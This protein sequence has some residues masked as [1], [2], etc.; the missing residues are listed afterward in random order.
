MTDTPDRPAN[1]CVL[2]RPPQEGWPWRLSDQGYM[3]CSPCLDRLRAQLV[4]IGTRYRRLDPTPGAQGNDGGRGAPGF[5]SKSPASDHVICLRDS[6]S[7]QTSRTWRGG[8]GRL[9]AEDEHPPISVWGELDSACW[10]TAEALD[11]EGPDT[12]LTVGEQLRWLDVRLNMIT[13]HVVCV[14]VADTARR[15]LA[16]LKPITGDPRPRRIGSCPNI[17]D[18]DTGERCAQPLYAPPRGDEIHC[19]ACDRVWPREEW[20]RLGD[21]LQ[22]S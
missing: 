20:L 19:H 10:A 7:S 9:H 2:H 21:L 12:R 16:A 14:D 5:G 13:Q 22:A 6:R 17:P 8:D 18:P 1:A 11:L 3:T 4:D 15:V